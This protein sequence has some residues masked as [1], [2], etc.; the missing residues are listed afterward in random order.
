MAS[1]ADG[2]TQLSKPGRQLLGALFAVSAASIGFEIML[3]RYFAI[4]SWSEYG[5][6]VISIAMAGYS[7]SGVVLSLFR[8]FF[9]KHAHRFF[10]FIPLLL[11]PLACWGFYEVTLNPF[12]PLEFQNP[13]LWMDQFQNIAKYYG[14]LFPVFFLSGFYISLS[15]LALTNERIASVYAADLVGAGAGALVL[16]F[17]M[18]WV[19]P[20]YLL[21]TLIPYWIVAALLALP[22][23][24]L[25]S[26]SWL[27]WTTVAVVFLGGEISA[28]KFNKARFCQ[29]KMIT[30]ALNVSDAH[31]EHRVFSPWGYYMLL[32]N[33]T[34]RLDI[35]LSNNYVLLKVDG[36]P[37]AFGL[38]L[39]G[40]RISSFPRG[41]RND[42]SYAKAALDIFPYVLK[43]GSRSLLIGSRGGFR[44]GEALDYKASE[45]VALESDPNILALM[46]GPMAD[47]EKRWIKNKAVTLLRQAPDSY[48]AASKKGFD[49]IDVSSEFLDQA[50]ANKYAFTEESLERYYRALNPGGVVSLPVNIREFTVYALKLLETAK[51]ALEGLGVKDPAGH[52]VLYR[53]AWNARL[54][55][56]KE[57]WTEDGIKALRNFCDQRSF[58][59]S[60]YPGMAPG[61][62]DIFNDLPPTVWGSDDVA[63]PKD[64]SD[65]LMDDSL[66]LLS[67]QGPDFLKAHFFN[68]R[69]STQDRPSFYSVLRLSNLREIIQNIS[70]IPREEIGYLI[71]IAVLLQSLLWALLVLILPWLRPHR[72]N[73]PLSQTFKALL[74]FSCL[75]LGFLFIEIFLIEKGAYFLGDRTY[76]FSVILA[77]MLVFAGLGSWL[78]SSSLKNP[79][80]GLRV[81]AIALGVWLVLSLILFNWILSALLAWPLFSKCLFLIFWSALASI[82]LGF[83]FPLGLSRLPRESG[84]IPWAWALNGAFSVVA[85]PLANLFAITTGYRL[86]VVAGLI[87]YGLAYLAFPMAMNGSK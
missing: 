54:L 32:D 34:E 87:L 68:L 2:R 49:I 42:L 47:N 60:Y 6:W 27:V 43:P 33:F 53:S 40:N 81:A 57:P 63:A 36:P 48:L 85:T 3:T 86:L 25:Q 73:F 79:H 37:R 38:Y 1:A 5:Y 41:V 24:R 69:P 66:K 77:A 30:P 83:F 45:L 28:V 74:Y 56:S 23:A 76:S 64:I 71:N 10:F 80:E 15:F 20:F 31:V 67:P 59:I 52:M 18:F 72:G 65:A 8:N 58:D 13:D 39:D 70:Q 22:R 84:L 35:D 16:L 61:D 11:P 4:A 19:H 82:P 14:A 55:V 50:D 29:Y 51:E 26:K 62:W 44:I 12:N 9:F 78:S 75:G 46:Q 17:A 21:C 7:A